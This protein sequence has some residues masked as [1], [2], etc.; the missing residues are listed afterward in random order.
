[1]PRLLFPIDAKGQDAG[2]RRGI[3]ARGVQQEPDP[4]VHDRAGVA[5][6]ELAPVGRG[7]DQ[8][9][10]L[11]R[12]HHRAIAAGPHAHEGVGGRVGPRQPSRR[13]GDRRIEP[14][15]EPVEAGAAVVEVAR[16]AAVGADVE[17]V[18]GL[19]LAADGQA[20][21][22]MGTLVVV[23][24]LPGQHLPAVP[25]P[26]VQPEPGHP[27]EV[28]DR[29]QEPPPF[30][31][32][33]EAVL[34]LKRREAGRRHLVG[35]AVEDVVEQRLLVELDRVVIVRPGRAR[36]LGPGVAAG[37]VRQVG[38]GHRL[39]L[40]RQLPALVAHPRVDSREL[41][42]LDGEEAGACSARA[43]TR[44]PSCPAATASPTS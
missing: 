18:V 36:R 24:E 20:R 23:E 1:M 16:A 34:E 3:A 4:L 22:D 17:V 10:L 19:R 2:L 28:A 6:L 7:A 27:R 31:V 32:E 21:R 30:G 12:D 15:V 26:L 13:A 44:M 38:E 29:G 40:V 37:H 35:I 8:D 9:E 41:A 43:S 5:G 39:I 25:V 11:A 42:L 33:L 14:P